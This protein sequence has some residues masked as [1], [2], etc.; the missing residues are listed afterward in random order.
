MV[1]SHDQSAAWHRY[2]AKYFVR[3]E[4]AQRIRAFCRANLPL[5]AYC[6]GQPDDQYPIHSVYLDS[7][8]QLFLRGTL[9]KHAVR[10]KLR[11]RTYRHASMPAGDRPAFFE[12]KRKSHGVIFKTRAK[13]DGLLADTVLQSDCAAV[14]EPAGGDGVTRANLNEFL[15]LR[16]RVRA[17]PMVGVY[18]T[19]EA[20]QSDSA[21]RVRI[22]FDR[23]LH[24]G[25]LAHPRSRECSMWWPIRLDGVIVEIKFTNTFPFWLLDLIHRGEIERRGVCKYQYC[26][27]AVGTTERRAFA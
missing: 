8:D 24:C 18:Y 5:D 3:E 25:L 6:V 22:S 15:H 21:D 16:H 27:E 20:Y 23:N 4:K 19:R 9:D 12:I 2:E 10:A 17:N 1:T 11:V 13:V 14:F 26:A 7:P